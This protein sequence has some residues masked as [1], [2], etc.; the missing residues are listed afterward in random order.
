MSI[1]VDTHTV[2]RFVKVEVFIF[3]SNEVHLQVLESTTVYVIK[4]A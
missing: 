3:D 1:H 4:V 2:Y